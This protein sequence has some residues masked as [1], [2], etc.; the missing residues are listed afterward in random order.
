MIVLQ[1]HFTVD[2]DKTYPYTINI[3]LD[4]YNSIFTNT[5]NSNHEK[6][7]LK[8]DSA[9]KETDIESFC[10]KIYTGRRSSSSKVII[11]ADK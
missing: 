5:G 7:N 6:I 4:V 10:R 8:L 9:I 3:S 11:E 2:I 1:Q